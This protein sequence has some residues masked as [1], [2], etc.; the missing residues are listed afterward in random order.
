M[1][2]DAELMRILL[3]V[4]R[5]DFAVY[6]TYLYSAEPPLACA[7]SGIGGLQDH[8]V[9]RDDLESW[10]EETDGSFSLRMLPG[11]HFFLNTALPLLLR[12]LSQDLC[13]TELGATR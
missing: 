6:E 11:G 3:P 8:R 7:I 9:S 5:A 12:A 4:L 1:L 10:R 13:W 2:D